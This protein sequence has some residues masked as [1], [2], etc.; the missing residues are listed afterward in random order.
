MFDIYKHTT[1]P[2]TKVLYLS[3]EDFFFEGGGKA[4]TLP[5]AQAAKNFS[6]L[7]RRSAI[8]C[9]Q[10]LYFWKEKST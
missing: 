8:R 2:E 7:H 10:F 6:L 3:H 5:A 1:L 9:V 4:V